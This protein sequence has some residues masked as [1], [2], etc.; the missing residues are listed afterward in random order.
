MNEKYLTYRGDVTALGTVGSA[1]VFTTE[2]IEGNE[3][4]LYRL[5]A[6]KLD[7]E[8]TPLP[9]AG[10]DLVVD[11]ETIWVAGGDG[12]VYELDP[13]RKNPKSSKAVLDPPPSAI[14]LLDGNRLGVLSGATVAILDRKS[15]E[16]VQT[17]ELPD[18]GTAL[19]SDPTGQWLVAGTQKGHV[20]VFSCEHDG[21]ETDDEQHEF[22]PSES[23][24]L[25]DGAVTALS[26]EPEELRFLSAGT[27]GKLL[28]VHARGTLE[29]EDR[30][31][32]GTHDDIVT[33]IVHVPG[34]RFVTGSRDGTCKAWVRGEKTRPATQDD[35]VVAVVA[36]T[37]VEIHGRPHLVV[38]CHDRTLRFFLLDTKGKITQPTHRVH[39]ALDFVRNELGRNEPKRREAALRQLAEWNDGDSLQLLAGAA[40]AESDAGLRRL[41]TTLIAESGHAH[42]VKHL[43][44]L[45]EHADEAVR[46]PAFEG[47]R[48]IEGERDFRPLDLALKTRHENV[49]IAA[50]RALAEFA[51]EDDRAH[52]RLVNDALEHRNREVAVQTLLALEE[53]HG[54]DPEGDL[55][56]L[57]CRRHSWVRRLAV[58]RCHQRAFLDQPRVRSA[59][60]RAL[61]EDDADVRHAAFHVLV[62]S[63]PDLA[64]ALRARDADLHRQLFEL[65]NFSLDDEKKERTRKPPKVKAAK[66]D[67]VDE[68]LEPLLW[69]TASRALDSCLAGAGGL[70]T[71]GDPRALGVLLQL[72][73]E[74]DVAARVAVARG[75]GD[76][77]DDRGVRRLRSMLDDGASDVRDAAF[78]ALAKLHEGAPYEAAALGLAASE[79]DVRRRALD[80][81]VRTM[82][83]KPPKTAN[84]PGWGE[85]RRALDDSSSSVRMEAFKACLNAGVGGG[86]A[87]TLRFVRGS[88]HSDVRREVLNEARAHVREPWGW[89]LLLEFLDDPAAAIRTEALELALQQTKRR[90]L[91]PMEVA[92][93]SAYPDVRRLGIEELRKQRKAE[94]RDLLAT[95]L[96]DED[97]ETR[98]QALRAIVDVGAADVVRQALENRY[99]DVRLEAG[100]TLAKLGDP[101][102]YEPLLELV[103]Q[104][105]PREDD[106]RFEAWERVVAAAL[107]GLSDLGDP[108]IVEHLPRFL[109]D[110]SAE[111]RKQAAVAL[112]WSSRAEH[113]DL[114][115]R[116]LGHDDPDVRFQVALGLAI[117]GRA[118]AA[119]IVLDGE[120]GSGM[121]YLTAFCLGELGEPELLRQLDAES[122]RVRR[123]TFDLLLL[124]EWR[125][126]DGTPRRL[127]ASLSSR[128]VRQR[129]R[130]TEGLR[131]FPDADAFEHF[132]VRDFNDRSTA[133]PWT[134]PVETIRELADMLVHGEDWIRARVLGVM[135]DLLADEQKEFDEAWS[136]H[137]TRFA[138]EFER[139]AGLPRALPKPSVDQTELD[140]LAFGTYV[141]IVREQ[142]S[143]VE[144]HGTAIARL[145][146]MVE[147][148]AAWRPAAIPV[149]VQVLGDP[150]RVVRN[151]AF[152]AL[153][154]LSM[155][156]TRLAAEAIEAGHVDLGVRALDELVASAS[157]AEGRKL[158]EEVMVTRTDELAKRAALLARE[159]GNAVKVAVAGL[160]ARF[161]PMRRLAVGWLAEGYD[162]DSKAA[163]ALRDALGSR[164]PEVREETAAALARKKDPAAF[165]ALVRMLE[166]ATDPR[167]QTKT[168]EAIVEL[169]D[170]RGPSVLLDRLENDPTGTAR[171]KELIQGAGRFRRPEDADR[172]LGLMDRDEWRSIVYY[173]VKRLAGFDQPIEDP[174]DERPD[175]TWET[176]QHPRHDDVLARL[177]ER[178]VTFG[179]TG[180]LKDSLD[181]A[182][183]SRSNAVDGVLA[184]MTTLPDDDLRRETVVAVGWRLR[185]RD[186][187]PDSLVAALEHRDADTRFLAAE[188]LA[189][190]GRNEGINV[191]LAA[192]ELLDDLWLR[193]R[194]VTALGELADERALDMLLRFAAEHGHALQPWAAEAIGH[195]GRSE[196]REAIFELLARCARNE[197]FSSVAGRAIHG[198][199]WFDTPDGWQIVRER[200]RQG[201]YY[202]RQQALEVL[203][204]DDEPA[205]RDL[206]LD[207][208]A[209]EGD[210]SDFWDPEL[211]IE[212]ARILFGEESLEPDYA[213]LRSP[214]WID[215]ADSPEVRRVVE[216]GEPE[217]MLVVCRTAE[218]EVREALV[219]ALVA[220]DPLP[221]DAAIE[222]LASLHEREVEV[223][224]TIVGYAE[225]FSAAGKKS[226]EAALDGWLERW[227]AHRGT[228]TDQELEYD[229]NLE[230][231]TSVVKRLVWAAGRHGVA[232]KTLLAAIEEHA[233]DSEF[234]A[235]R[236]A[237]V[238]AVGVGGLPK[239]AVKPLR[240]MLGDRDAVVRRRAASILAEHATDEAAASLGELVSDRVVYR[241]MAASEDVDPAVVASGAVAQS[242]YQG[243]VLPDVVDAGD[244][245]ALATTVHDDSLPE[246]TRLGAIEGLAALATTRGEKQLERIGKS[247]DVDEELRKAAWRGLRRSKRSRG[248]ARA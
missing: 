166:E 220:R 226:L 122:D 96:D 157:A 45:L 207:A 3:S 152:D 231:L 223:A 98:Q 199:R 193:R 33:G 74:E 205:T 67:L 19:A 196:K 198:L 93:R 135:T 16:V 37:V 64:K 191:L 130:A 1:L 29:P 30:G 85:L 38:A 109:A 241:R 40:E 180:L 11:G 175:R 12:H 105:R 228:L 113:A 91:R 39:G 225:K 236:R 243:V 47:L 167:P 15:T 227:T 54:D 184:I 127:L 99:I 62:L 210:F 224:A 10:H 128:D 20:A 237:C 232:Q 23:D 213:L 222:S 229:S 52:A 201:Q 56:G 209:Q 139:L 63:R 214:S 172:L 77:G 203:R 88:V 181:G 95:A 164:F 150:L 117:H 245:G 162:D 185:K 133:E 174:E 43:E 161:E 70:A 90:D 2:R 234:R 55:L 50:T 34:E 197:E 36:L 9:C 57:G 200:A 121:R 101:A 80:L 179:E 75:L 208:I 246:A 189:L 73:R 107:D 8:E 183:W 211:A 115:L 94:A 129:L 194:A 248:A 142:G 5:D 170:P 49:A 35:G 192:V 235:I 120:V 151:A 79:E 242:H 59:V 195:L 7:L 86:G 141:A 230:S 202:I 51:A 69:A 182:R 160:E 165:E 240:E 155:E 206:L 119:P 239:S 159:R 18:H 28:L 78:T 149:L 116:H 17:L 53:V 84:N 153:A 66:F 216:R 138:A 104:E 218:S 92:I 148:D 186:A 178:L 247:D 132:V 26:F 110:R 97:L 61:D 48:A 71:L 126:H 212:S 146:G 76:L 143:G 32:G 65:E 158:L 131:R 21:D 41:A 188:G 215:V 168:I 144:A 89:D 25:H 124:R 112:A 238:A 13:K 163:A 204:H 106:P 24:K 87:E 145:S 217:R 177:M 154:R 58:V 140:S 100:R 60:R 219:G 6:E 123:I 22:A 156:T 125:D 31:R 68:D 134:V 14:V 187:A 137:R 42:A 190:G 82:R 108:R 171:E 4:A 102:S 27:D 244:E 176:R 233:E 147:E 114:L 118:E 221:V 81:A 83:R 103:Q 111:V 136:V 173:A 46:L 169:G 44:A 72:S